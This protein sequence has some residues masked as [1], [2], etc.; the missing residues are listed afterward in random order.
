MAAGMITERTIVASTSRATA[1]PKP[2]CW[3][4]TSSPEA[5]PA[6]TTTMISAAPVI[7]RAVDPTPKM[8][9]S[10]VFPVAL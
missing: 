8:I 4:E 1:T 7:R 2:I 3:K 9:A 10:V 6:K 5:K